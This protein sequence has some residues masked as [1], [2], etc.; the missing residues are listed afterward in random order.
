MRLSGRLDNAAAIASFG[1][2]L[3]PLQRILYASLDPLA[4]K[5]V[6]YPSPPTWREN[7]VS[8]ILHAA[9]DGVNSCA[10]GGLIV[11]DSKSIKK[12][13]Y[14]MLFNIHH[15]YAKRPIP[16]LAP[17]QGFQIDHLPG[18]GFPLRHD[19]H[20]A[21]IPPFIPKCWLREQFPH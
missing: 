6:E 14:L 9:G 5:C 18:R 2:P 3:E 13:V 21:C 15:L 11:D 1:P 20:R 17:R 12:P 19:A 4:A 7:E 16:L 10:G 8:A